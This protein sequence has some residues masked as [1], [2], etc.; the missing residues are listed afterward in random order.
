MGEDFPSHKLDLL[1]IPI[2]DPIDITEIK[3]KLFKFLSKHRKDDIDVFISPGTGMMQIAWFLLH[4]S[5]IATTNLI[6][7][8]KASESKSNKPEFFSID[9]EKSSIPYSAVLRQV[10]DENLKSDYVVGESI[11]VVYERARKIALTDNARVLIRGE[12]GTGKEY[13]ARY[14]HENSSRS[15]KP[16]IAVNCSALH[17]ELLESRLFGHKRGSFTSAV[18]DHIGFFESAD[19]GTIFLDEIGDISP[20]LQQS[21]LRVLQNG[22]IQPIGYTKNKSV[23]VRIISATNQPLEKLCSEGKFRWDLYYRI[24]VT[25]LELPPLRERSKNDL[26]DLIKLFIQRKAAYFNKPILKFNKAAK[27]KL[28]SYDFPGNIRELENLIEHF[29]VFCDKEIKETDFPK[30]LVEKSISSIKWSDITQQ[31]FRYVLNLYDGNKTKAAKALG[32]SLNTL[33]KYL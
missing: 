23:D 29:Y 31:H 33:K 24:N 4:L 32:C 11:K 5:S 2:N 3:D 18:Q 22:E 16:F 8:R 26:E 30:R 6:Q 21:L 1:Y 27:Q 17:D 25:E 13:L 28:F 20:R 7:G 10:Y 9:V 15:N 14:I 19:G 12:S